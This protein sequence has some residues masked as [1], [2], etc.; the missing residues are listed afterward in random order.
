MW[1]Q[2]FFFT[3]TN[4]L[5]FHSSFCCMNGFNYFNIINKLFIYWYNSCMVCVWTAF[6]TLI[7]I[8][9]FYPRKQYFLPHLCLSHNK[10]SHFISSLCFFSPL[11]LSLSPSLISSLP[12]YFSLYPPLFYLFSLFLL[13]SITPSF[14]KIFFFLLIGQST[15]L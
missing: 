2:F 10:L 6:I 14:N 15:I 1:N 11:T 8:I 5:F 13:L 4:F 9:F 7:N 12:T 3:V